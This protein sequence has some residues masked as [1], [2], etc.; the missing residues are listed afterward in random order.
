[1]ALPVYFTG[2]VSVAAGG[3]VVTGAGVMWSGINA[4]QG[5]FISIN[6]LA[7][8]LITEVTDATHLKIAPW[9]GPAQTGVAYAI[10]QNYV[11]RVVGVAAAEDVGVMLEKLHVDG[12]PFILGA[13]ETVPDPSYGDE[14]QLAFRP[15]TGEWWEKSGGVWVVSFGLTA[16]GY[17]GTSA[18]SLLIGTGIKSFTT[19]GS[20]AYDGARVRAASAA[21]PNNWMEGIADY[22]GTTLTMTS[23]KIGGS[24]THADWLFAIAGQPGV[25]GTGA[26][27][28]LAAN[29]LSELTATAATARKNI[30]AAPFDALAYSGMQIN[31]SMEVSRE[32]GVGTVTL[33]SGAIPQAYIL[34]GWFVSKTGTSV[35]AAYQIGPGSPSGVSN[36]LQVQATTPQP[37]IG[38]DYVRFGTKIEGYRFSRAAWGTANAVPVTVGF[39]IRTTLAGNYRACITNFDGASSAAWMTFSSAGSS[40]WSWATITFPAMTT[41]TWK[42]DNSTGMALFIEVASSSVPNTVGAINQY[43]AITGVVV[44]P[45][46]EAPTAARSPLIMRPYDQELV[47]CQRYWNVGQVIWYGW[48]TSGQTHI[49]QP[50]NLA[51]YMRVVPAVAITNNA[52]TGAVFAGVDTYAFADGFNVRYTATVANSNGNFNAK[53]TADARL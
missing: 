35:L 51:T 23:D 41:G 3:T 46:I 52:S 15:S 10:Y 27:D 50:V 25:D 34:D 14:G 31:G 33:P 2:T 43:A 13:D 32:N 22:S 40:A 16:L 11:G 36:G 21:N 47:T 18:T 29:N 26:G 30:Y 45:G 38:S 44:L 37:T 48:M 4:K 42:T 5:D 24:G 6:N 9:Q 12:L 53:W 8:V 39:W 20:L 28:M 1:M 7:E 49:S 19:Q 17:G